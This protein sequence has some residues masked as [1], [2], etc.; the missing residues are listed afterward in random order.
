MKTRERLLDLIQS[1][2][3][4]VRMIENRAWQ[5]EACQQ[6][7]KTFVGAPAEAGPSEPGAPTHDKKW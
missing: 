1:Q 6:P 2:V 3:S 5:A 7:S 4:R